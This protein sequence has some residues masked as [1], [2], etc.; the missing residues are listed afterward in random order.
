MINSR[1]F[2]NRSSS[3]TVILKPALQLDVKRISLQRI[4]K[5]LGAYLYVVRQQLHPRDRS[6]V[7]YSNIGIRKLQYENL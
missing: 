3:K 4:L 2:Y 1:R 6:G 5:E 7:E